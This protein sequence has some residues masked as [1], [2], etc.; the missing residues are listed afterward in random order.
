MEKVPKSDFVRKLNEASLAAWVTDYSVL[1]FNDG[2]P[3]IQHA[4]LHG[5]TMTKEKMSARAI[6]PTTFTMQME[7]AL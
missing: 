4:S 5:L 1:H 2:V 6:I 7:N 3:E